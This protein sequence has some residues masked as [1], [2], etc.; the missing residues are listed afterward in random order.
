MVKSEVEGSGWY[1]ELICGNCGEPMGWNVGH[2][3]KSKDGT[4]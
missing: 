4:L 3:C 1:P 2:N